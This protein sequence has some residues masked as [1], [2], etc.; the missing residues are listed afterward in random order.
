MAKDNDK[1]KGILPLFLMKSRILGSYL[2]SLP[3]IDHGGVYADNNEVAISLVK[4]AI[5]IAQDRKLNYLELRNLSEIKY[6]SL[7]T[8]RAKVTFILNL[9]EGE[10]FLW[11]NFRKQ[12][13]NRIRK[14]IK[15]GLKVDF[16]KQN[17]VK[18][19]DIF[20]Q[21]MKDMG[22]PVQNKQ[23]FLNILEEFPQQT[24]IFVIFYN[25]KVIATKLIMFFKD[26]MF[27]VWGAFLKEYYELVPNY[28]LMWEVIRFAYEGGYR[29]C[30]MG[31]ST[32]NSG[33]YDFKK[34][35]G[36]EIRQLYWQYYLNKA[37]QLPNLTPNNPKFS[38]AIKLW[39]HLPLRLTK[40]LG[41]LIIRNIP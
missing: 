1:I 41:P 14:G 20:S 29:F 16:G 31:R 23:F 10:D 9:A 24:E 40:L 35:W 27:L 38:L 37:K 39:K 19:Y 36:P 15:N 28:L 13:R 21:S 33:P 5:N 22:S 32:I 4:R 2:I 3:F 11:K 12:V 25:K 30:N 6:L 7:I 8:K 18:F 34:Q 26:T 17:F